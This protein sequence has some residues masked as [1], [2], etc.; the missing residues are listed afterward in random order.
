MLVQS[1][2]NSSNGKWY[3]LVWRSSREM[4]SGMMRRNVSS[5]SIPSFLYVVVLRIRVLVFLLSI[6]G[7][8]IFCGLG[9]RTKESFQQGESKQTRD[10]PQ[11][12]LD[13]ALMR[14]AS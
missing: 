1:S 2:S 13:L 14:I 11:A 7:L 3:A 9:R 6:T 4:G 12:Q 10:E 5:F 8:V